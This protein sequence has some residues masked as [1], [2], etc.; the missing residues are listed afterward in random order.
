M[1]VFRQSREKRRHI[2]FFSFHFLPDQ[3]AGA[4][5]TSALVSRLAF[6][7][8][9]VHITV[10]CSTP[11]RY[12]VTLDPASLSKLDESINHKQITIRRFWVPFFGTGPFASVLSYSFYFFQ[13]ILSAVFLR[14]QL[15]VGTSAKLLTSL[16][17][18]CSSKLTG[19]DLYIDFR[20]TFADNFFYFYRW[21]KRILLQSIIMAVENIVFRCARSINMVSVGFQEA[22]SGWERILTKYS[23]S[24][25]NFP[26][27]IHRSFREQI[28]QATS[29]YRNPD[30]AY[31]IAYVG[32]L[33]DGQD[34][35]GLLEDIRN[36]SALQA[37]MRALGIRIDIYGSG[38]QLKDIRA[39]TCDSLTGS[40]EHS[41]RYCGLVSHRD[42]HHIYSNVD[43]LMLQ[44]GLY[45]S[46]SMVIPTK[47]FEYA[48]TP[49]PILFG[50]SGF[51]NSFITEISGSI[52]FQQCNGHSFLDAVESSFGLDVDLDQR[53]RFLD[54]FDA[55][56]IYTRYAKHILSALD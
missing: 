46:L 9:S 17:A 30:A 1:S 16:V 35:L 48:A 33:G 56:T 54:S 44:L 42:V 41:V 53:S 39:L 15:V 12:G 40:L 47:V 37:R 8:P 6:L 34:I 49:Y 27:G 50:A 10:F 3:S 23:I 38:S 55:D 5:R 22:F 29:T 7:D 43:C 13:S 18:A 11:C 4:F 31:R 21:N 36:S 25:T 45:N 52:P 51:T 19:A 32:N 26:N 24:L 20:D 28:A 14:P 2:L